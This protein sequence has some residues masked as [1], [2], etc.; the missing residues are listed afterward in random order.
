MIEGLNEHQKMMQMRGRPKIL[1]ATGYGE[2]V[3]LFEKHKMQLLGVISDVD[4]YQNEKR[5][6]GNFMDLFRLVREYDAN[7]PIIIHSSGTDNEQLVP[8]YGNAFIDSNSVSLAGELEGLL[9]KNFSFGDFV[10]TDPESGAEI[11]R[12]SDLQTF[13]RKLFEIPCRVSSDLHEWRND[14]PAVSTRDSAKFY[15]G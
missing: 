4:Q 8:E 12:I 9:K 13:Q 3:A 1:L 10:F 2:A 6:R 11:A 15:Q 5:K 7:I 14:C